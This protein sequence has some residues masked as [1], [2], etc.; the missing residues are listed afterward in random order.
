MLQII[1]SI[2]TLFRKYI[3]DDKDELIHENGIKTIHPNS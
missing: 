1:S 3:F 2:K